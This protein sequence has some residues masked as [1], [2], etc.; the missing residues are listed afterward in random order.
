[1]ST[2]PAAADGEMRQAGALGAGRKRAMRHHRAAQRHGAV[3]RRRHFGDHDRAR[4]CRAARRARRTESAP[5]GRSAPRRAAISADLAEHRHVDQRRCRARANRDCAPSRS[6]ARQAPARSRDRSRANSAG[7]GE[8]ERDRAR[9]DQRVATV[10]A[11]PLRR[12]A[13][14]GVERM[15]QHERA[16]A[17]QPGQQRAGRGRRTRTAPAS[18]G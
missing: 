11:A 10:I 1:M 14:V 12:R 17:Q 15:M 5:A 6:G 4:G 3:R 13:P 8:A 7:L 9:H 18:T 16:A 2:K